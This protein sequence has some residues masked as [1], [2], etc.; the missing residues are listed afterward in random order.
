MPTPTPDEQ[1]LK[2]LKAWGPKAVALLTAV[3]YFELDRE[4]IVPEEAWKE[5]G[6]RFERK[7]ASAAIE[8]NWDVWQIVKDAITAVAFA[9]GVSVAAKQLNVPQSAYDW[10]LRAQKF[11]D[12]HGDFFIKTMSRTDIDSLHQR[13]QQDFNLNPRDFGKRFADSYSCSPSR[14]E[15]IKRTETHASAQGGS[16]NFANEA[17]CEFKQ[18][19]CTSRAKWPRPSH[20]ANWYQVRALEDPFDSGEIYPGQVN[21]RCY[22]LYFLDRDHL[23][24][25][26]KKAA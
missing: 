13:I 10:N 6:P 20:R 26:A 22:L 8:K 15:R 11:Y 21:C 18:W 5:L 16:W 19:M 17:E 14:L 9:S 1:I 3:G 24:W 12:E 25:G 4:E 7:V 2:L 23:K